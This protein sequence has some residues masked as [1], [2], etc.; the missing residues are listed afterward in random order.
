[1]T[2][3]SGLLLILCFAFLISA[4][5][6]VNPQEPETNPPV[7]DHP[8]PAAPTESEPTTQAVIKT[9]TKTPSTTATI[10]STASPIPS[11]TPTP[12]L[13]FEGASVY[14]A[15]VFDKET[16]FYLIVPGVSAPYYGTVDQFSLSCEADPNQDNLLVCN[17][18]EN[19]FGTDMKLFEFFADEAKSFLVFKG[20]FSTDLDKVQ[21]TATP[22]GFIWPRA[23][24]TSADIAWGITPGNC[25]VRGINLTCEIEYRKYDDGSCLVGIS[26]FD[27]CGY[28]YSVDTIKNKTGNWVG[29]GP[30]W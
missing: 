7:A 8:K 15:I 11:P 30:C 21:P 2:Q 12:F 25:S 4:C 28:Y 9:H 18:N 23:D 26:C 5:S 29:W 16:T 3:R 22:A 17:S 27:S 6:G 13:G 14:K 20:E 24:F 1:M 19:L 10:T